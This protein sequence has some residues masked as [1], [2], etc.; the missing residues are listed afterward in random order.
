MNA[1]TG[2]DSVGN[3]ALFGIG[4]V[5]G[6]AEIYTGEKFGASVGG[7]VSEAITS[8]FNEWASDNPWS[9]G[10][11]GRILKHTIKGALVGKIAEKYDPDTA[12]ENI[13]LFLLSFNRQAWE[14]NTKDLLEWFDSMKY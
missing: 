3:E 2:P 11:A 14:K 5:A 7:A 12:A 10:S 6:A 1:W 4:F 13:T 8:T 9:W